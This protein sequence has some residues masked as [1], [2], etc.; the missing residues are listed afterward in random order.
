MQGNHKVMLNADPAQ[1]Y[2]GEMRALVQA[3][4]RHVERFSSRLHVSVVFSDLEK[5]E[6]TV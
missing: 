2:E 1:L 6:V 3:G 5:F 4:K